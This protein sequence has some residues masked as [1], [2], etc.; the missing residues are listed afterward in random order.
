MKNTLALFAVIVSMSSPS[1]SQ[2]TV[3]TN[4]GN[5][6]P[7][8]TVV[9]NTGVPDQATGVNSISRLQDMNE[10]PEAQGRVHFYFRIGGWGH[11]DIGASMIGSDYSTRTTGSGSS[12]LT[13]VEREGKYGSYAQGLSFAGAFGFFFTR[14]FGLDIAAGMNITTLEN[15]YGSS[16]TYPTYNYYYKYTF[17]PKSYLHIAPSL[18]VDANTGIVS[19]YSR[20]GIIVALPS[21]EYVYDYRYVGSTGSVSTTYEKDVYQPTASI[22]FQ[23]AL[24]VGFNF[25]LKPLIRLTFECSVIKLNYAPSSYKVEEY[26]VNGQDKLSTLPTTTVTL[27]DK[28][29]YSYS[30]TSQT[31]E[32]IAS[33]YS[34]SSVSFGLGFMVGF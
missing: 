31:T 22:G 24:G 3:I 13:T 30:T 28:I 32:A 18:F 14:N 33:R 6:P 27:K 2:Q 29:S 7:L 16:Y 5:L 9:T 1:L 10:V 26:L 4:E 34:Y 8:R 12:A 23:G 21:M 17:K 15:A 11:T 20:L 25:K 19:P